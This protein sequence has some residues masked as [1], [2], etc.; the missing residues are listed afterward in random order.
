MFSFQK[1]TK[2]PRS[3]GQANR[4]S[5]TKAQKSTNGNNQNNGYKTSYSLTDFN[6]L[7]RQI[8]VDFEQIIPPEILVKIFTLVLESEQAHAQ[9][10]IK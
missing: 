4:A 6:C 8:K 3:S 1:S 9:T 10:L 5:K 2:S 7:L